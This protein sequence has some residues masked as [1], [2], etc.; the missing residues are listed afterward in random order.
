ME[1]SLDARQ[2]AVLARVAAAEHAGILQLPSDDPL[3]PK[4][5]ARTE[6]TWPELIA[7]PEMV[8]RTWA[9]NEKA[10]PAVAEAIRDRGIERVYLV[11]AGDSYAVMISARLALQNALGVP[12]EA[13]QSLEF[14]FY[15]GPVL[16]P[17]TLVAA[18][19]SSGETTRTVEA[20]LVAQRAGALTLA[21][22]NT[23]GSTLDVESE[24][25]LRIEATRVGW[26]T[27]SSTAA[28]ALLLKLASPDATD[29]LPDLMA[30]AIDALSDPIAAIAE[31]EAGSRMFLFSAGGPSF[32]AALAGAAKYK[33]CTPDHALAIQVEEYHHY[34]SQ[35]AG[36]PLLLLAPS[37]RSVPRAAETRSEALRFGG[38]A[39]VV[40]SASETAF[41]DDV[42]RLP[43]VP[44][45]FSPLLTFLPAQ[46]MGYHAAMAK[47]RAAAR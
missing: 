28:L 41:G 15:L 31:R 23:A 25:T 39:Y 6:A 42:L 3:D 11:G 21:L 34:N 37:G 24:Q 33:E 2:Q 40:T 35:K 5:L 27:Q 1:S 38:R 45:A 12:V 46:L 9:T 43:D 7:Q 18:L 47:F 22:T 4:R 29:G 19:S 44:E 26:P 17:R 16:N 32:G 14:A 20:L 36:E 10:L 8:R 13:V 30:A